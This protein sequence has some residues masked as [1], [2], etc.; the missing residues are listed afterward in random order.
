MVLDGGAANG[1]VLSN[2]L[3]LRLGWM[4]VLGSIEP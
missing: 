3:A 2:Q 1:N 4:E